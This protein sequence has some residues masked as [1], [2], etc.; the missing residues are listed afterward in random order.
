MK[1]TIQKFIQAVRSRTIHRI[2]ASNTLRSVA[3]SIVGVY[4][5]A[6]LLTRGFSLSETIGFYVVLHA[7]GLA[8]VFLIVVPLLR[9][10]GLVGTIKLYVPLQSV[11][12]GLFLFGDGAQWSVWT[13]AVI[14]G[15][16][17]MVYYVPLNILFMK[18]TDKD[19][20]AKDFSLFFALPTVFGLIGPLLGAVLVLWVGF[21]AAFVVA[22]IGLALS[23]IP[24]GALR[25]ADRIDFRF[26]EALSR[27]RKRKMLFFLE[28]FDNIIEES[29]WFWGIIVFLIIG[30]LAAPGIVGFLEASGGAAFTIL[31]GRYASKQRSTFPLLF[32]GMA[33]LALVWIS[34]FFIHSS[35]SAYAVTVISSFVMT[36]FLVSYFAV[37]YRKVKG[38]DD[39]EFVILREIPTILGRMVVF[40]V[41]LAAVSDIERFYYLPVLSMV[42]LAFAVVVSRRYLARVS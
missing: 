42:V 24:L 35:V 22:L 13:A 26:M 21:W 28:G 32:A 12:L 8:A 3:L 11:Y 41:A 7:V 6:F 40:A 36:L 19:M 27:A 16:A 9:T 5:P 1:K 30:S 15:I 14:G 10:L 20:I 38:E 25:D 31:V 33:G 34:R 39:V 29:E 2:Q 23:F 17:N 4:I 37:I 18:H